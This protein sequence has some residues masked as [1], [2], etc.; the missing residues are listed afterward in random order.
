VSVMETDIAEMWENLQH[1]TTTS[2]RR[3]W[4]RFRRLTSWMII[5]VNAESKEMRLYAR[6]NKEHFYAN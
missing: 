4:L 5:I 2:L 3:S 1:V 6:Q